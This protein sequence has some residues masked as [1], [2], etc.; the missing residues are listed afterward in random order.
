MIAL[1]MN[2]DFSITHMAPKKRKKGG[3]KSASKMVIAEL[4]KRVEKTTLSTT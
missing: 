4:G 3:K 2:S 1:R